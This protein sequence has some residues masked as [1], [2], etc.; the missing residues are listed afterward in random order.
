VR[1]VHTLRRGALPFGDANLAGHVGDDAVRVATNR[2]ALARRCDLTAVVYLNQVHGIGVVTVAAAKVTEPTADAVCTT[3]ARL[4]CAVLTADCLPVVIA[5]RDGSWVGVAHC[6]WRGL[7]DGV[8]P[9][10]IDALPVPTARLVA[11]VGP[12]IG[13]ARYEVGENVRTAFARWGDE[14]LQRGFRSAAV[15]GKYCAD[16][17]ALVRW[18]LHRAGLDEVH[19]GG[20]CTSRDPR[21]YSYRRDG[22]TG[23][24]ATVVWRE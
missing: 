14:A 19:G 4:G 2:A 20:F 10:L 21:F 24:F 11:Y 3:V 6:G 18:Q 15:P 8:L 13:A 17:E 1:V 5:A 7:A 12:G 22:A 9:A 23:R 16:L